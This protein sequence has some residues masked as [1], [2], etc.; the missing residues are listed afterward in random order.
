ME[1]RLK[2]IREVEPRVYKSGNKKMVE[3]ICECGNITQLLYQHYKS[4]HTKSCGCLN[5]ERRKLLGKNN[6]THNHSN[7]GGKI[8]CSREY[9]SWL[10]MKSRCN[11]LKNKDWFNYGG[12]GIKVCDRWISSFENFLQDMGNRPKGFTIDR[13]DPNGNYEP[14]NCRWADNKTQRHNQRHVYKIIKKD[15]LM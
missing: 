2:I 6:L 4:N 13:I 12:R 9:N 14:S 11:Y 5:N 8:K 3:C 15:I 10:S 1:T 7:K